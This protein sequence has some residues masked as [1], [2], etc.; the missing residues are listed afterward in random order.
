M[1]ASTKV[2]GEAIKCMVRASV[3]RLMDGNTLE[4]LL[5]GKNRDL[6]NLT[7]LMGD[8]TKANGLMGSN[9]AWVLT[10]QGMELK[11]LASGSMAIILDGSILKSKEIKTEFIRV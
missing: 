5:M 9:M 3:L 1:A 8:Y 7:G 4:V 6:E 11:G 10:F 2:S